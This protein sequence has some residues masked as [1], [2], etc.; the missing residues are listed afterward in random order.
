MRRDICRIAAGPLMLCVALALVACGGDRA[1]GDGSGKDGIEG[2]LPAPESAGGP[3]TGMPDTPARARRAAEPAGLPPDTPVAAMQHWP[4][5]SGCGCVGRCRRTCVRALP[6]GERTVVGG[7]T[8]P[9][10]TPSAYCTILRRDQRAR[11]RTGAYVLWSDGGR[12]SGQSP[13]QFP[14]VST[15]RARSR[16]RSTRPGDWMR[17]GFA[18]CRSA[19]AIT[20]TLNDGKVHKYVA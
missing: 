4:A 5:A 20:T 18:F 6:R 14:T 12:S 3:V 9:C 13:Q 16:C 11:L 8:R 15:T 10:R 17:R 1:A 2:N 19:A 7:R